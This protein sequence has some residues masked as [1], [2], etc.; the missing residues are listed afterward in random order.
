MSIVKTR[1]IIWSRRKLISALEKLIFLLQDQ[2][3]NSAV[4]DLNKVLSKFSKEERKLD[5]SDLEELIE[6]FNGEHDLIVYTHASKK[7]SPAWGI[8]EE[9][10]VASTEVFSLTKRLLRSFPN[11]WQWCLFKTDQK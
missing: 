8:K 11:K 9:L 5:K 4:L 7:D 1:N 2:N 10:Y 6:I 3:E